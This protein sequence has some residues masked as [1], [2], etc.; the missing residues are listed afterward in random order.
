MPDR[1]DDVGEGYAYI[2]TI[3]EQVASGERPPTVSITLSSRHVGMTKR[4]AHRPNFE[5]AV[6]VCREESYP[7]LVR[8]SGG[9]AIAAGRGTFG[10]SVV[11]P[12]TPQERRRGTQT[13]YDEAASLILA[14]LGRLGVKGRRPA[15]SKTSSVPGTTA[16]GW[17]V[18]REGGSL[19]A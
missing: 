9:G 12:A 6:R 15:R 11:R 7:V 17:A 14:S 18:T 19:S 3:F 4:D 13:R 10:F 16:S 2:R 8:A 1:F 5:E